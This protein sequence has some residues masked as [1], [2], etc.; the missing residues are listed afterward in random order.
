[1]SFTELHG[2]IDAGAAWARHSPYENG[3]WRRRAGQNRNIRSG[4][5]TGTGTS[6]CGMGEAAGD[7]L[8]LKGMWS[9]AHTGICAEDRPLL[10]KPLWRRVLRLEDDS[11]W[12]AAAGVPPAEQVLTPLQINRAAWKESAK[13]NNSVGPK[14]G[15]CGSRK[16]YT[17]SVPEADVV[18]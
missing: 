7:S 12:R 15:S 2:W 6:L 13:R 17:G 5:W 3:C 16:P 10:T 1:M 14:G 4:G 8:R 11:F 9:S 18:C